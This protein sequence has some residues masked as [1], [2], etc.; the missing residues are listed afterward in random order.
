MIFS[1]KK[2][3]I[4]FYLSI[5]FLL[6]SMKNYS[7]NEE[8]CILLKNLSY[9]KY[10]NQYE[11]NL[12][13]N[14]YYLCSFASSCDEVHF[15]QNKKNHTFDYKNRCFNLSVEFFKNK[16]FRNDFGVLLHD[17]IDDYC[18]N[19]QYAEI[20]ALRKGYGHWLSTWKKINKMIESNIITSAFQGKKEIYSPEKSL[21][22]NILQEQKEIMGNMENAKHHQITENLIQKIDQL[23]QKEQILLIDNNRSPSRNTTNATE[24]E[25]FVSCKKNL[26]ICIPDIRSYNNSQQNLLDY[27]NKNNALSSHSSRND[28]LLKNETYDFDCRELSNGSTLESVYSN[29]NKT[30]LSPRFTSKK[31]KSFIKKIL[32]TNKI[33]LDFYKDSNHS[34]L[35]DIK[36]HF[37]K[38]S[39]K[40][41][42]LRNRSNDEAR[43]FFVE[44]M[45]MKK[46]YLPYG[47][48]PI[49]KNAAKLNIKNV[50]LDLKSLPTI[51]K[52]KKNKLKINK[53][54]KNN[55]LVTLDLKTSNLSSSDHK[56][57]KKN[58]LLLAQRHLIFLKRCNRK[59]HSFSAEDENNEKNINSAVHIM[60][61]SN[62]HSPHKSLLNQRKSIS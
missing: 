50:K 52:N 32:P 44:S 1:K 4:F 31:K 16:N 33:M 53:N 21:P 59:A 46:K 10:Y 28:L 22:R 49:K 62:S 54:K 34:S 8:F 6:F 2:N 9:N 24:K 41:S 19:K 58:K 20:I 3:I 40:F 42:K 45:K 35:K 60:N 57:C 43:D 17:I 11:R 30:T 12:L 7:F 36:Y 55:K 51:I 56:I 47:K 26:I 61:Y 15:L 5:F 48:I 37:Y 27:S 18:E 39:F 23:K 25:N 38:K 13:I 29:A 14:A